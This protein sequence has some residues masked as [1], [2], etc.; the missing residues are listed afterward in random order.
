MGHRRPGSAHIENSIVVTI[1]T[2]EQSKFGLVCVALQ[3]DRS[4]CLS[5][6]STGAR[7]ELS[8]SVIPWFPHD[9]SGQPLHTFPDHA[10]ALQHSP[11]RAY[12]P[13][14]S[15]RDHPHAALVARADEGMGAD[16]IAWGRASALC[17]AASSASRRDRLGRLATSIRRRAQPD[18]SR[19]AGIIFMQLRQR[20][21]TR[22]SRRQVRG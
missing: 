7:I 3:S 19:N 16:L 11:H 9:L 6:S 2:F 20:P 4:R 21:E 22:F 15:G 8:L 13:L 18:G 17:Q 12:R 5:N 10:L 1:G 14:F